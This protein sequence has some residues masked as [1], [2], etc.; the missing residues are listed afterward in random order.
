MDAL[1]TRRVTVRLGPEVRRVRVPGLKGIPAGALFAA[2]VSVS[3]AAADLSVARALAAS[4]IVSAPAT[5][6]LD[7]ER[8]L[9]S[10]AVASSIASGDLKVGHELSASASSASAATGSLSIG[11]GLEGAVSAGA[12]ATADLTVVRGFA[13]TVQAT[14]TATAALS[15]AAPLATQVASASST[16]GG[17]TVARVLTATVAAPATST[18]S[19]SVARPLGAI[20]AS[21]SAANATLAVDRGLSA[22]VIASSTSAGSLTVVTEDPDATAYLNA[23]STSPSANERSLVNTLV[24]GI[25]ADGDW[26]TLDW[27]VLHAAESAQAGRLNVRVPSKS[28]SAVNAPTFTA[29][30]GFTGDATAAYLDAGEPFGAAGTAYSLND[31]GFGIWINLTGPNAGARSSIG[32]IANSLRIGI[33]P[34]STAGNETFQINDGTADVL[35]TGTASHNGH[36]TAS[37]TG[38][39]VKRGFYNGSRVADLT[40]ASTAINTTNISVLRSGTGYTDNR[41]AVSYWGAGLSDAA[42]GRIHARL[43]TYLNAKGAQ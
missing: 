23:Q 11:R 41:V 7:I 24:K 5:A 35:M 21:T 6:R 15:I 16:V 31:A 27:L 1:T 36:R 39:A 38:L 37:R 26:A 22:A 40:T 2:A 34:R 13:A 30:R 19:L 9:G 28:M 14:A 12:T 10:T 3:L 43:N 29:N 8:A 17:L 25:K 33:S 42:V 20:G 32:N 4:V 18:G